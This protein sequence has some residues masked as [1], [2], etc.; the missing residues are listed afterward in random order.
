MPNEDELVNVRSNGEATDFWINAAKHNKL[1][2]S[3]RIINDD[4]LISTYEKI[5][6]VENFELPF[7][8]QVKPI[9]LEENV[10]YGGLKYKMSPSRNV[11]RKVFRDVLSQCDNEKE[12]MF[13]IIETQKKQIELM[14]IYQA[15]LLKVNGALTNYIRKN[16]L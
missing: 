9:I 6:K 3:F 8:K 10:N 5:D 12:N 13:E 2:T 14:K 1:S 11:E 15:K 16:N 7:Q 4:R